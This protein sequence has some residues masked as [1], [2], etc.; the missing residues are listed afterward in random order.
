[1]GYNDAHGSARDSLIIAATEGHCSKIAL[2][3]TNK[4]GNEIQREWGTPIQKNAELVS[5]VNDIWG[6]LGIS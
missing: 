4:L 1:M 3:A 5:K 2:D 6:Q